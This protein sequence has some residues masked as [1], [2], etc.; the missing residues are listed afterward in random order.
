MAHLTTIDLFGEEDGLAVLLSEDGDIV[1]SVTD[2]SVRV[3]G[4]HL[5]CCSLDEARERIAEQGRERINENASSQTD[6]N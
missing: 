6:S 1:D 3:V 5:Y 2:A 4:H